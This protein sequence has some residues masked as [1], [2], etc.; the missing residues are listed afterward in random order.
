MSHKPQVIV[1]TDGDD[2][3]YEAI[4]VACRDLGCYP[5]AASHGNPTPLSG[6]EL[7]DHILRA[8]REP[9][10]VM[11]DDRGES[12]Q[13]PGETALKTL[14]RSDQLDIMGVVA[15]AANTRPVAGVAV[16]E[17]VDQKAKTTPQAVDK[18][19]HPVPGHQLRGDTVDVLAHYGGP[20]VGLGDPGKM[21]GWDAVDKGV[22]ATRR[23]LEEILKQRGRSEHARS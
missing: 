13:G 21:E 22:P 16:Q 1:V 4:K 12:G 18:A 19:G 8:P 23:A 2:T 10:V 6:A 14:L 11:V 17:S 15:V 5:L 9:V 3:A 20:I 7:V